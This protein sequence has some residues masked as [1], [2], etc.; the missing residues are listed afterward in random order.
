MKLSEKIIIILG[1]LTLLAIGALIIVLLVKVPETEKS[2]V[3]L[4]ALKAPAPDQA[5]VTFL[6]GE[7]FVYRNNKWEKVEIGDYFSGEDF[8][9]VFSDS[10]CEVQFGGNAII[11]IQE[12]SLLKLS[13]VYNS[14]SSS[15]IELDIKLG[16]LLCRVERITGQGKFVVKSE[17]MAFG[18]R[19]TKFLLRKSGGKILLA[20]DEGKVAVISGATGA[21]QILVNEKQEIEIDDKSKALGEL[22]ALSTLSQ[23]ELELI[24]KLKL[25]PLK[26]KYIIDL[27]KIALV[28]KPADAE[29]YL[30]GEKV[31]YGVYAGLFAVGE[32]LDF[33]IKRNGYKD[34]ALKIKTEKGAD[35]EYRIKL[36][37][38]PPMA[39]LSDVNLPLDLEALTKQLK[40]SIELLNTKLQ[41]TEGEKDKFKTKIEELDEKI[42]NLSKHEA[43]LQT[44]VNLLQDEKSKLET[45]LSKIK[46]EMTIIK[47]ELDEKRELLKAIHEESGKP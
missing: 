34:R 2:V 12:N 4:S 6:S 5:L 35:S 3:A 38:A 31:G 43:E 27:V 46:E 19:G 1:L 29:I 22:K 11:S 20:V 32:E 16:T 24:N 14:D 23:S 21:E 9:R 18:V 33:L 17:N 7:V 37:L 26:E 47:K 10:Y 45:D 40:D 41:I 13:E 30:A 39:G 42:K 28:V 8:I 36:E 25:L 15:D 44:Q